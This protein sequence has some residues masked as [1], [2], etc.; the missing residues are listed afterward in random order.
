MNVAILANDRPSY[1]KPMADALVR[2]LSSLGVSA[3]VFYEGT[4]VLNTPYPG[5]RFMAGVWARR[6]LNTIGK[7]YYVPPI[8]TIDRLAKK[9]REYDAVFVVGHMPTTFAK[10]HYTGVELLRKHLR[11]P[12]INY[13]LCFLANH[14][15]WLKWL[16]TDPQYGGFT[17]LGRFDYYAVVSDTT[18]EAL[19]SE[20][21][22]PMV[23]IG[24]HFRAK[25][26]Y[27]E[28][29]QFVALVDFARDSHSAERDLQIRAL[30]E[31]NTPYQVLRGTYSAEAIRGV[32]RKSA[33]YFLAHRE[34]FGLPIVELQQCGCQIFTPYR[35]WAPAHYRNKSPYESGEGELGS[36]FKVYR[37]EFTTLKEMIEKAKAGFN[38][39]Q[40][41]A[42][43]RSEYPDFD[44]GNTA[45][46][47]TVIAK[48]KEGAIHQNSHQEYRRLD[49]VML[50]DPA[51]NHQP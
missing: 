36:N 17:G 33:I 29:D 40:V 32:Y 34:S 47:A 43:F 5:T 14:R 49:R 3:S 38:P 8:T 2:M 48:L 44:L 13:D 12:I 31:T 16:T 19:P 10:A 22:F 18:E 21:A 37:N 41:V 27:P 39:K 6:V 26:L 50:T 51:D 30:E 4:S 20:V 23:R 1:Y 7:Q 15:V 46:L 11:V 9:L 45:A 35:R 42:N 28:Q 24:G 25:N